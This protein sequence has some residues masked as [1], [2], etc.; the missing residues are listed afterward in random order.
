M[1]PQTDTTAKLFSFLHRGG[2]FAHWWTPDSGKFFTSKKSGQQEQAKISLW[3]PV[4]RPLPV[5][6]A[7][8]DKNVY[9][10]V[11]PQTSV[12]Q[13]LRADGG[14]ADQKYVK[15]WVSHV[16]AVNCFFGEY[17]VKDFG[18]KDA[19][20]KHL[21]TLPLY[22]SVVI[23]SGGGF[24]CYWLLAST[25]MVTDD[26]RD[27]IKRV[28]YAWVD[29]VG[30][31]SDAK[32]LAR[33]LRVPG[34][35]N[36]KE[37]Y[38]PHYPRVTV[39]EADYGRLYSLEEFERLTEHLR[40]ERPRSSY[41]GS[42]SV[43][44]DLVTAAENLRRLSPGRRDH[45]QE[46][47]KVGMALKN[48]GSA[49]LQLWDEWSRGS[50]KYTDGCCDAK[51]DK[52]STDGLGLGSLIKW[53]NDDDPAG[54]RSHTNGVNGHTK[55]ITHDN[56]TPAP[57]RTER[58]ED[59]A[60]ALDVLKYRAEDGGILDAWLDLHGRKWIFSVGHDYWYN[61]DN[62]HW[63][64]DDGRK[65]LESIQDLM[66][67]MNHECTR[68]TKEAPGQMRAIGERYASAGVDIPDSAIKEIERLKI[69]AE[70]AKA[71]HKA[72]KRSNARV[73]SVEGMARNKRRAPTPR[74]NATESLNLKNG[75]LNLRSFELLAHE[76][77]D[78]FTYQLDYEYDPN[79]DCPL[80]KK[81][82]KDVLVKEGT[83]EPDADLA[84]LFQELMGYSLTT[85]MNYQVMIWLPGEG[86]NGKSVAISVLKAL[87]GPLATSI[88][89]QTLGTPGNYDLSD[90]PGKRVVFSMEA[91]KGGALSEKYIKAIADGTPLKARPIYGSQ[92]E[93]SSTAK[94]WWAMNDK[95]VIRDTTNAIWRRMKM[96]PFYR[97]FDEST[98]DP[99]LLD[100]LL[101]ELPGILNWA[102]EG[103]IRLITNNRF[104]GATNAET[105]KQQYRE[106][107]N[108]VVQWM[109]TMCVL[110][111]HP[112]TLQGALYASFRDW[113][114]ANGEKT[115]IS[116]TQLGID[117]GRLKIP[118]ARR[119]KG[120]M[121]NLALID[122]NFK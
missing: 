13:K 75:T 84:L 70:I 19:I 67:I 40:Q 107:S 38:A 53:A 34:T 86:G 47:V 100:K 62:T 43:T 122:T 12:P 16:A 17:D 51:W 60:S 111:T 120:V 76:P 90:V 41:T 73:G 23:D 96:I 42:H 64:L 115:I 66:D 112:A 105:A 77:D 85:R 63:A 98:A 4:D 3:Y 94:I 15:A 9:F 91:E 2:A 33:V 113:C 46:W 110:T 69:G 50:A 104:T 79:A 54:K 11:H 78:L 30:S 21:H 121:Y 58:Q 6:A 49:G 10:C 114:I 87:L 55:A 81:F 36:R 1:T 27:H 29:F 57:V 88:D 109:N 24:H 52:I 14:V 74:F 5:P 103:L 48:L 37:K 65:L 44:D 95:P 68:I 71:I 118:K 35:L 25:V 45:Y 59:D 20:A 26:N 102:I 108:P 28:Q 92:I 72:T 7:W 116:A 83:T 89:F 31:D 22:P 97:T 101:P 119:D 61:W 56:P 39:I 80:W 82:I 117:L 18:S 93:F 99:H 106:Q 32:D 8:S